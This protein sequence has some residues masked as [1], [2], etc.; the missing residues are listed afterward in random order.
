MQ[1]TAQTDMTKT[2]FVYVSWGVCTVCKLQNSICP[3]FLAVWPRFLDHPVIWEPGWTNNRGNS[4]QNSHV[5]KKGLG[6]QQS[7]EGLKDCFAKLRFV[8]C[9]IWIG[10]TQCKH[11]M[12]CLE[13]LQDWEQP[14]SDVEQSTASRYS[15]VWQDSG[16]KESCCNIAKVF[17]WKHIIS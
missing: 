5:T 7:A 13:D 2:T 15:P 11:V 1:S 6:N 8:W 9:F 17:L 14:E 12:L 3:E 16:P 4:A 10:T